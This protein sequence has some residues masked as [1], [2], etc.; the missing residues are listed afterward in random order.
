MQDTQPITDS[1]VNETVRAAYEAD[2]QF[3][4]ALV[5]QF[6]KWYAGTMRYQ[7]SNHNPETK[8]AAERFRAASKAM[9]DAFDRKR[10]QGVT[11]KEV[12]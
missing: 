8:A 9:C 10:A 7:P 12:A 6:G 3:H 11:V 2:E 5:R 1:E 4:A